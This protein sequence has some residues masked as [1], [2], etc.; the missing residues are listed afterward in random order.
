V[1]VEV[2]RGEGNA[3]EVTEDAQGLQCALT[4]DALAGDEDYVELDVLLLALCVALDV[5]W[6]VKKIR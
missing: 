6:M 5:L 2:G 1:D 3:L 4:E